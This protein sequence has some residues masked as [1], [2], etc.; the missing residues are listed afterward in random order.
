MSVCVWT[1]NSSNNK[2]HTGHFDTTHHS[3]LLMQPAGIWTCNTTSVNQYNGIVCRLHLWWKTPRVFLLQMLVL[4][5]TDITRSLPMSIFLRAPLSLIPGGLRCDCFTG[6]SYPQQPVEPRPGACGQTTLS[7]AGPTGV[8]L[9]QVSGPLQP[10]WV[11]GSL[12]V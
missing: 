10:G 1:S 2:K 4:L 5:Q 8:C 7:A 3:I 6:R 11:S 12:N 9:P